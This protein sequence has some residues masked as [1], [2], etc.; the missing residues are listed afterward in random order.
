MGGF[1]RLRR[2]LGGFWG[3]FVEFWGVFGGESLDLWGKFM[4]FWVFLGVSRLSEKSQKL[5]CTLKNVLVVFQSFSESFCDI[6]VTERFRK[7]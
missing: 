1:G 2:V 3:K 4:K 6:W 7:C 5:L